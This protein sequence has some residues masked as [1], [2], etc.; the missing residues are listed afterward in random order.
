MILK[1]NE[2]HPQLRVLQDSVSYLPNASSIVKVHS[3]NDA[4][5]A[6]HRVLGASVSL[7]ADATYGRM[8]IE[9]LSQRLDEA[10][11][12]RQRSVAAQA[13]VYCGMLMDDASACLYSW[14]T[15]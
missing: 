8:S 15:E 11:R 1:Q 12:G 13:Y 7:R 3:K 6:V 10:Q 14:Q 5:P 9:K 4:L 2:G